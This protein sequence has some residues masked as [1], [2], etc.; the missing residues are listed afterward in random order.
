MRS[1]PDILDAIY[2]TM[3]ELL[4]SKKFAEADFT[5]KLIDVRNMRTSQILAYLTITK[6][7]RAY[8]TERAH[9]YSRFEAYCKESY[10]D[11]SMELVYPYK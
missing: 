9:L 11:I 1:N 2:K 8:L 4:L 7:Y 5:L 3:D 10:S 6:P